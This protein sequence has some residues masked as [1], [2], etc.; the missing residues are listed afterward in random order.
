MLRGIL[1]VVIVSLT[2]CPD[3]KD[4]TTSGE[5]G[6]STGSGETT[7][8]A[9]SSTTAPT[10]SGSTGPAGTTSETGDDTGNEDGNCMFVVGRTFLSVDEMECGLDPDT[11]GMCK[12]QVTFNADMT[13]SFV[14][15]DVADGGPYTCKA[16]AIVGTGT[17]DE[18]GGSVD[19]NTGVLFWAGAMYLAE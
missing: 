17:I 9:T 1:L 16:G 2:A 12:W 19:A 15:S 7:V 4:P 13:F 11:V 8:D 10:S 18:Y 3:T 14:F 5:S 6:T